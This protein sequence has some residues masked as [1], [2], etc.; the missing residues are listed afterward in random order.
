[1]RNKR[2]NAFRA[3]SKHSANISHSCV[4]VCICICIC[5]LV[6]II[7]LMPLLERVAQDG[8]ALMLIMGSFLSLCSL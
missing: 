3:H 1:M 7:V 4:Y 5:I 8:H 6:L 2:E